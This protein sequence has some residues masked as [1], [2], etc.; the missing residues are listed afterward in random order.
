MKHVT[1]LTWITVLIMTGACFAALPGVLSG[2]AETS[3]LF[4]SL[5][6]EMISLYGNGIY[7]NDSLSYG[8][9]ARGQDLVTLIA[10]IPLLFTGLLL[11]R[12]G[13]LRGQL[14][15]TGS[16]FY[17]LY[18]YMSYSYLSY[19]NE[20][21][22]VYVALFSLSLAGSILA[23]S[24]IHPD[25]VK[26]RM[27]PGFPVKSISTYLITMGAVLT[28]MWLGRIIPAYSS[29]YAPAGIDHYST[30]V[31]Q[32][33]DL[34]IIAPAAVVTGILLFRRHPWG[35]TLA[36]VLLTKLLTM[37]LALFSMLLFMKSSGTPAGVAE[38][39]VFTVLLLA[40]LIV[41]CIMLFS[42][43]RSK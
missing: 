30:L 2:P 8:A 39:A 29:G 24:A 33:N 17:F 42:V 43:T 22:L 18:T 35:Y 1:P 7:R 9:Q 27:K 15:H 19:F 37:G 11:M 21:F 14:L 38:T 32:A 31:I 34:G 40:G 3:P 13:S 20:F 41:S 25:E 23:L 26:N 36:A 10:G 16:M 12:R 6:G 28:F 5:H 4:T